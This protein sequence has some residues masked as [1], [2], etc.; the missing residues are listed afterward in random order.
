VSDSRPPAEH[1]LLGTNDAWTWA[2]EFCRIFNG[3]E[4]R[5]VPDADNQIG[6][7]VLLGWF[8]NAMATAVNV[9]VADQE[10]EMIEEEDA[11]EDDGVIPEYREAFV[12]GFQEGREPGRPS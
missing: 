3:Y 2:T 8:A 11:D 9:Y 10:A 4:I 5:T 1:T 7:G 6:P 12:E